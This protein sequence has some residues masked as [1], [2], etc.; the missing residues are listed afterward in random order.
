MKTTHLIALGLAIAF[1]SAS[2]HANEFLSETN[3]TR[4][5][6]QFGDFIRRAYDLKKSPQSELSIEFRRVRSGDILEKGSV[7]V[8][9]ET[10]QFLYD[11]LQ[12]QGLSSS[13]DL[14]CNRTVI[15]RG[16]VYHC[17]VH[18]SVSR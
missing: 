5:G 12:S 3:F 11:T 8:T 4:E 16:P 9:G 15:P 6:I 1:G 2:A 7:L 18:F 14:T 13:R 17:R 10:A